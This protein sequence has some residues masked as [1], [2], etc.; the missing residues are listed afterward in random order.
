[1]VQE[2][3]ELKGEI[4]ETGKRFNVVTPYTSL[5]VLESLEEYLKYRVPPPVALPDIR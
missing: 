3:D 5:L 4:L 1:M 2:G